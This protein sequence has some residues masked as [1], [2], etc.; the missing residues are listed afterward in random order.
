MEENHFSERGEF[1]EM[2][3]RILDRFLQD[4]PEAAYI[5]QEEIGRAHV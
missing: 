3:R 4:V 2:V 1:T 5:G